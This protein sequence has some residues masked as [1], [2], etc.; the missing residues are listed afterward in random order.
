MAHDDIDVNL[1]ISTFDGRATPLMVAS[2]K[3]A[4]EV[5]RL[6]LSHEAINVRW[7]RADGYTALARACEDNHPEVV[8]LLLLHGA[9]VNAPA[10]FTPLHVASWHGSVFLSLCLLNMAISARWGWTIR[11]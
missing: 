3:G 7:G 1:T 6:L 4:I 2:G 8:T 11:R 10:D 5:V 9:S